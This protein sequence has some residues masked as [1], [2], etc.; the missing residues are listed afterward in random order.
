MT[1]LLIGYDGSDPAR[2]ATRFAGSLFGPV[3]AVIAHIHAPPP[4]P[5]TGALARAALP[6]A[7]IAEG[8]A[9]L[10]REAEAEARATVAEG[11]Q[12]A[13]AAGLRAESDVQFAVGTWRELRRLAADHQ[14]DAIVCGN[15]GDGVLDRVLLG[16]TASSLLHHADRPLVVVPDGAPPAG[17]PIVVGYDGSDGARAAMRFVATHLPAHPLLV[18]HAWRSPVRHTVRGHALRGSGVHALEDYADAIDAIWADMAGEGAQ[19][20]AAYARELGLEARVISPESGH[21]TWRT[22]LDGATEHTAVALVV[23]SRGRGAAASTLLGSVAS[24][25]VH[26]GLLPV[27]VVPDRPSP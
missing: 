6:Q 4:S 11:L 25:L 19:E 17:G 2:A 7:M 21:S 5:A 3:D 1:R 10:R 24:G 8:L 12:V 16:S 18:A 15:H 27:I 22:L 9:Q 13:R 26:A 20:G 23:G 14:A